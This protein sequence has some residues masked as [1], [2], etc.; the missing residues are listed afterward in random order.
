VICTEFAE[1]EGNSANP[2]RGDGQTG[3]HVDGHNHKDDKAS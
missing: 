3:Y 1:G 2:P